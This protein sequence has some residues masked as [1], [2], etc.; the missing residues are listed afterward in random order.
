MPAADDAR[1]RAAA[2]VAVGQSLL[3]LREI[4]LYLSLSLG[5]REGGGVLRG[6]GVCAGE[7]VAA[8]VCVVACEAAWDF[9]R[10]SS[11][12]AAFQVEFDRALGAMRGSFD[13]D[14]KAKIYFFSRDG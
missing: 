6:L 10:P 5:V 2:I 9:A 8:S 7:M 13:E 3:R 11:K 1:A 4:S 14:A 12:S